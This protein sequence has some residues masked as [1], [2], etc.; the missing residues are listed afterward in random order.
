[1]NTRISDDTKRKV[2]RTVPGVLL[3]LIA[4]GFLTYG[5]SKAVAEMTKPKAAV[6]KTVVVD[7]NTSANADTSNN[8]M[9][10]NTA[11]TSASSSKNST[12]S[13]TSS[14]AQS[15]SSSSS[16]ESS[17]PTATTNSFVYLRPTA[18]TSGTPLKDLEAGTVVEYDTK[19]TTL[20][21][22][23]TVD[24]VTGYVYKKFLTY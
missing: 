4:A 11:S 1:M 24:G 5:A 23:V 13:S 8:T 14:S 22:Q 15:S 18:A 12:K 6:K 20:W 16:T 9:G 2:G 3:I 19:S 17:K 10:D 21:Q 7:T